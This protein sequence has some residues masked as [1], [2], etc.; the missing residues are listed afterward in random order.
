[1]KNPVISYG[2]DRVM[3]Y[4]KSPLMLQWALGILAGIGASSA[5]LVGWATAAGESFDWN[6]LRKTVVIVVSVVTVLVVSKSN[7]AKM[8]S[9]EK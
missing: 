2:G 8:K 4:L 3:S 9:K 6:E 7:L 5:F 1:M